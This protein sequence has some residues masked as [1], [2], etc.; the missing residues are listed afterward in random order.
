MFFFLLLFFWKIGGGN[1]QLIVHWVKKKE[2]EKMM[3]GGESPQPTHKQHLP[4]NYAQQQN[5]NLEM[6]FFF[7]LL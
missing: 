7:S 5:K 3:K 6:F 2:G 4:F 1:T